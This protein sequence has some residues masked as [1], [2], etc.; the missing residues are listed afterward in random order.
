MMNEHEYRFVY[1]K[2][3][4]RAYK[5]LDKQKQD[6]VDEKLKL[7]SKNPFHPSLRTKKLQGTKNTFEASVTMSIRILWR[8]ADGTIIIL[9]DMGQHKDILGV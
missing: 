6:L 7:M 8:Y 9:L 4:K 3:F 2:H 1:E 5:K